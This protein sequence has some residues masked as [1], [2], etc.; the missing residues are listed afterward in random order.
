[1]KAGAFN[2]ISTRFNIAKLGKSTHYYI[3]DCDAAA[4]ELKNYGKVY[5]IIECRTLDKRNLKEYARKYPKAEMT[6]RNIPMNT[7]TLRKK[8]G[9]TSG[10]DAHIFGLRSDMEGNLLIASRRIL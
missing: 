8:S 3:T 1:M 10:D 9:I 6:A 2:L 4:Q 7:E 5:E